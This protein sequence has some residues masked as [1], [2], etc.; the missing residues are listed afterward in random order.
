MCLYFTK[1]I[2]DSQ[3][4]IFQRNVNLFDSMYPVKTV[5]IRQLEEIFCYFTCN[6]PACHLKTRQHCV[7]SIYYNNFVALLLPLSR[8]PSVCV[9]A[10]LLLGNRRKLENKVVVW[11]TFICRLLKIKDLNCYCLVLKLRFFPD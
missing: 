10:L 6:F 9:Y 5:L 1:Y 8:V 11:K 2:R 3:V 4:R 7:L